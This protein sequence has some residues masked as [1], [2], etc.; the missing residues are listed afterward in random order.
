MVLACWLLKIDHLVRFLDF[1]MQI[2]P[3]DGLSASSPSSLNDARDS[4]RPAVLVRDASVIYPAVDAPVRALQSVDLSIA[5]GEFVALIGPSGCGKTTLLRVIAD[6]EP[7][8]SGEVWVNGVTPHEAR[9]ARA[10][11]YVFQAPALFPWRTVLANVMLPL[12][13]QGRSREACAAIAREQLGRVGLTQFENKYPWQLSG[14]MQQRVSIARAMA[15]E[16]RILMMD[17]PFGALD[18]IT[19]DNLN[20]QLQQL[21]LRE[22][23]TVV[24]VTHSIS[25]AVYLATRIVVM[26]P[27]PGRIA[28]VIESTLPN[29]RHLGLRDT[30]EFMQLAHEVREALADGHH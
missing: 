1:S 22:R 3:S 14:G 27:R 21:W 4:L 30:P 29:E 10:Y 24:F 8:S 17:E 7:I 28:K 5:Q 9:L 16:P 23:R 11:G 25:E 12:Q 13:I 19:R 15:F 6:L 2:S 20:E 26:S 18:E